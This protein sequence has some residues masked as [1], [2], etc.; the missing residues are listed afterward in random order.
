M[1]P[2]LLAQIWMCCKKNVNMSIGMWTRIEVYQILGQ[3]SQG[4]LHWKRNF[5]REKCG[6]GMRL[7]NIQTTTRPENVL[8]EAWT[9]IGKAG[10]KREQHEWA[11]EKPKLDNAR[12]LG[13]IY[14]IYPEDGEHKEAIKNAMPCKKGTKK[15]CSP[16]ET[17]ARSCESNKIRPKTKHARIVEAH[18]STRQRLES[19][20]PKGHEDHIAGKGKTSMIHYNLVHKF[21]PMP[22]AMKISGCESSSGQGMEKARNHT[23]LAVG[24]S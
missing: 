20:L 5:Q 3:D 24:Q 12:K 6:P 9:K 1:W 14:F 11:I 22:Y 16:Q 17:E 7:A 21:I 15:R 4:S 8:P 18:E 10:Q 23:S 2:G 19:S 13:G